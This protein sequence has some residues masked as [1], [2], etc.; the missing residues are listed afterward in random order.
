M[1]ALVTLKP[2]SCPF[3][4]HKPWLLLSAAFF[5][6]ETFHI[7]CRR[8]QFLQVLDLLKIATFWSH[9]RI[10]LQILL[11]PSSALQS[12]T[13][14]VWNWSLTSSSGRGHNFFSQFFGAW[15]VF[16][17]RMGYIPV[18]CCQNWTEMPGFVYFWKDT[19]IRQWTFHLLQT[20]GLKGQEAKKDIKLKG[21]FS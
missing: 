18:P 5:S 6:Q 17:D 12:S 7:R 19:M 16:P 1:C 2:G 4:D 13:M 11:N 14:F 21:R 15:E 20:W 3:G 9:L 10:T 8:L